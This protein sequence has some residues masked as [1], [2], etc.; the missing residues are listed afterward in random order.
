M[1]QS[2]AERKDAGEEINIDT[3]PK[4]L[5][6]GIY[7][8]ANPK[9]DHRKVSELVQSEAIDEYQRRET[10]NDISE[11][12]VH[13]N[14]RQ[15]TCEKKLSVNTDDVGNDYDQDDDINNKK[16]D[17]SSMQKLLFRL[18]N[19]SPVYQMMTNNLLLKLSP[20][21][22]HKGKSSNTS[23]RSNGHNQDSIGNKAEFD[24]L[25]TFGNTFKNNMSPTK[26]KIKIVRPFLEAGIAANFLES[27]KNK[28]KSLKKTVNMSTDSPMRNP[29]LTIADKEQMQKERA[30]LWQQLQNQVN[31]Y[32][33][34]RASAS[35]E[36]G[37]LLGRGKFA[38]V[39]E[40]R[41]LMAS[42]GATRE[43]SQL[44][45]DLKSY[46]NLELL[47]N[48]ENKNK[49]SDEDKTD[50]DKRNTNANAH[51]NKE[52][53]RDGGGVHASNH[54]NE[55]QKGSKIARQIS[56]GIAAE[57]GSHP[58]ELAGKFTEPSESLFSPNNSRPVAI[59]LA[60]Y[61]DSSTDT[62]SFSPLNL[63]GSFGRSLS[64]DQDDP[65]ANVPPVACSKEFLREI[66]ALT[67]LSSPCIVGLIGVILRPK[68]ALIL[69]LMEGNLSTRLDEAK[70]QVGFVV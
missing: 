1:E 58:L 10:I 35:V 32:E 45:I 44:S 34:E 33:L 51:S 54:K 62:S 67:E 70:W 66:I 11:S 50:I 59:K 18:D 60:Q 64:T 12:S 39:F 6:K 38:A 56:W 46:T 30:E 22:D 47:D 63:N 25:D 69:E 61:R 13:K 4:L 24:Q 41:M 29:V 17:S 5:R 37:K 19:I 48:L 31:F 28:K 7:L 68:L 26:D 2:N 40:G 49:N 8:P 15:I 55:T 14:A 52:E 21:H 3:P 65:T 16:H 20:L 9:V 53:G 43:I 27:L 36:Y 42:S 57:D 23:N